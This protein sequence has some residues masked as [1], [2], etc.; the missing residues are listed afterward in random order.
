MSRSVHS[1]SYREFLRRLKCARLAARLTQAQVAEELDVPQS[2]VSKCESGER[3]VDI[4]ELSR[5]AH[6]YRKSLRY[7]L[8]ES[9]K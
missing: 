2:Y 4:V 7:F 9:P 3:R 8:P 1:P 5:F 6:L